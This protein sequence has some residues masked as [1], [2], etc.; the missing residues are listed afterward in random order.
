MLVAALAGILIVAGLGLAAFGATRQPVAPPRPPRA[1]SRLEIWW[2]GLGSARKTGLLIGAAAGVLLGV[3]T[4]WWVLAL[5]LPLAVFA[6]PTLLARSESAVT[7]ERMS[8]MAE[9]VRGLAGV[10]TAGQSIEGAIVVSLKSAPAAIRPEVARLVYRLRAHWSTPMALRAFANDLND[11]TGD[12]IVAALLMGVAKRGDGLA[13]VL[14]GLSEATA[15]DV[16]VRREIESERD[17]PRSTARLVTLL[18]LIGVGIFAAAGEYLAPYGTP[19]GQLVLAVLL[20]GYVGSLVWLRRMS[21][22]PP[23]P[24]FLVGRDEG[25]L[26]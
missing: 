23:L 12:K 3:V 25:S 18:S 7:I 17:K 11:A 24:R 1:P 5:V 2:A 10:M 26:R 16:R 8:G 19:T 4:G 9:W 22:L 20:T 15:D 13:R 21:V 14:V 6:L